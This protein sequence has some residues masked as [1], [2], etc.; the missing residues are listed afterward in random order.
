M[1]LWL[2]RT[3]AIYIY[4]YLFAM[5]SSFGLLFTSCVLFAKAQPH[6]T[7]QAEQSG[8]TCTS[9]LKLYTGGTYAYQIGCEA[10]A[11]LS[12]G[13]WMKEKEIIRF[14]P[15]NPKTFA[16]VKSIEA[17]TV[18]GDSIWLTVLDKDGVNMSAKISVGLELS[19]R[20]SYLFSND[21]SGTKKFVYKRSGGKI[22]FRTLNKLFSQRIELPTDTANNF[23]VTLN[24]SA[25]W[26]ASTHPEWNYTSLPLLQKKDGVLIT[27]AKANE[28]LLFQKQTGE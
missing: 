1:T 24:L 5:K 17:T 14:T 2:R 12:F 26:M 9:T 18:P 13:K 11:Q 7:Y 27:L 20:G 6:E 15:V 8:T 3:K 23:V 21:A 19:G 25:D 16:V 28:Q 22:V 4:A 10:S